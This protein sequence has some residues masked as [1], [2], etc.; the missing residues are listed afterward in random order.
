MLCQPRQVFNCLPHRHR[1]RQ[2]RLQQSAAAKQAAGVAA[3]STAEH[4]WVRQTGRR[5]RLACAGCCNQQAPCMPRARQSGQAGRGDPVAAGSLLTSPATT[6]LCQPPP[7]PLPPSPKELSM[8]GSN[9]SVAAV[10]CSAIQYNAVQFSTNQCSLSRSML[11]KALFRPRRAWAALGCFRDPTT[12]TWHGLM[13]V[14]GRRRLRQLVPPLCCHHPAAL[15]DKA[16]RRHDTAVRVLFKCTTLRLSSSLPPR[17]CLPN[18][19]SCYGRHKCT[20]CT[21]TPAAGWLRHSCRPA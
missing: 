14:A 9:G 8:Q 2:R 15:H 11:L 3:P 5:F 4:T 13:V 1:R 20:M 12:H 16:L 7:S 17:R 10:Q 21:P 19:R 18:L 6:R